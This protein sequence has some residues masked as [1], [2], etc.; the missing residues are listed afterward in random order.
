MS[1]YMY[2]SKQSRTIV[3]TCIHNIVFH[4]NNQEEKQLSYITSNDK[5]SSCPPAP[6]QLIDI[7][8][9][10]SGT[11]D[12]FIFSKR[13]NMKYIVHPFVTSYALISI[14]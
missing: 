8:K 4:K 1:V 12:R 2:V 9:R 14:L 7:L 13:N 11:L 6:T 10:H 5:S 3:N